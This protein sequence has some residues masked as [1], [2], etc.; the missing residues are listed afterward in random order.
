MSTLKITNNAKSTLA[1]AIDTV[2]TSISVQGDDAALFPS[3]SADEWFPLTLIDQLGNIEVVRATARASAVITVTRAQEGTTARA[4]AS[5]AAVELRLTAAAIAEFALV[6]AINTAL[7]GKAAASHT[8][9]LSA[10]PDLSESRL[11]GRAAAAGTGD[12]TSLTATQV[13]TI[14]ALAIADITGLSDAL[15]AKANASHTHAFA[16]L[17]NAA[18]GYFVGRPASSGTGALTLCAPATAK[19]MLALT[20]ADI[21]SLQST[22]NSKQAT[23]SRLSELLSLGGSSGMLGLNGGSVVSASISAGDGIDIS[24]SGGVNPTIAVDSDVARV[25]TASGL[26]NTTPPV[27]TYVLVST[28]DAIPRNDNFTVRL[29]QSGPAFYTKGGGGDALSGT[30]RASGC[31]IDAEAFTILARR[32]A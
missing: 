3:L 28:N 19:S 5:G 14:L 10:L 29:H 12:A 22:L 6:D 9:A 2:D 26:N 7:S 16:D 8:H 4:F 15:T 17:P 18:Q 20:I 1:I 25:N 30:W 11:L 31:S 23:N 24:G 13:K 32:V 21:T 27:G